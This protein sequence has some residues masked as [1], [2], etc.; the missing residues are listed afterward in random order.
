MYKIKSLYGN[1]LG[2]SGPNLA[3]LSSIFLNPKGY[4]ILPYKHNYTKT[5]EYV[6][7]G[8][9]IPAY[10]YI[11][12]PGCIDDRGVT[13]TKKAR[14][15]YENE[16]NNLLDDPKSYMI[17]CAEYCFTPDDALA[18]EGDN[19]FDTNL[20]QEQLSNIILHK[21]GPRPVSGFLDYKFKPNTEEKEENICGFR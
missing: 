16:R 11:A 20:L 15:Y 17:E 19:Q 8:F 12:L 6:E 18:L 1:K 3:G 13:N 21:I 9:F 4:N 7:T 2:D 10:T 14:A 5:G